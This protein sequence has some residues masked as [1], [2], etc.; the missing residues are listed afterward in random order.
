MQGLK[1]LREN[2][3]I[4]NSVPQGPLKVKPVQIK[5]LQFAKGAPLALPPAWICTRHDQVL[6]CLDSSPGGTAETAQHAVL[7]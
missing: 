2:Y 4:C 5:D 3:V 6:P 1:S 7:G